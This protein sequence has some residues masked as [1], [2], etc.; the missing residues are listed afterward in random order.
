[1][2]HGLPVEVIGFFY[3][4][5]RPS[6]HIDHFSRLKM[7]RCTVQAF[8][9]RSQHM[10]TFIRTKQHKKKNKRT[11]QKQ[12]YTAPTHQTSGTPNQQLNTAA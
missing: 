12:Q 11:A 1:M 3:I 5:Q 8:Q 9:L 2:R 7:N 6:Q 4:L 10:N